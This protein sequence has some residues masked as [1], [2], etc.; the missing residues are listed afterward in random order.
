MSEYEFVCPECAQEI[1][2]NGPMREAIL[3]NGCPVCSA[4]VDTDHFARC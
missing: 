3:A 4:A 2:I 1:E